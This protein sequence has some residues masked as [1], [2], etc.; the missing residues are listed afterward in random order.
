MGEAGRRRAQALFGLRRHV[1]HFD[2]LY[3]QLTEVPS[4]ASPSN[5]VRA[6]TP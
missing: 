6:A 1:D 2:A 3:Q 4:D 5:A